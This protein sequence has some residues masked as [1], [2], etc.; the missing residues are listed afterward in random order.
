[1]KKN[2]GDGKPFTEWEQVAYNA[3][4]QIGANRKRIGEF[5]GSAHKCG[6]RGRNRLI[7]NEGLEDGYSSSNSDALS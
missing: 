4:F 2:A 6:F 5:M 3:G 7:F 1:M